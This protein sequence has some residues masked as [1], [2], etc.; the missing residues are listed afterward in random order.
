VTKSVSK[1][2]DGYRYNEAAGI[3]YNFVWHEFCDW[4]LEAIK[5]VL[6]DKDGPDQKTATLEVL[7][8]VLNDTLVLLHPFIPFIT[9]EIWHKLPGADGSIMTATYPLDDRQQT[10]LAIDSEAESEMKLVTDIITGVRNIRGEMD[11]P[12]SLQL[13]VE[14]QAEDAADRATVNTHRDLIINLAR[15]SELTTREPGRRPTAAATAIIEAGTI[16]V[17]LEGI[18]D[19]DKERERLEKRINKVNADLAPVIKKLNNEDFLNKAPQKIVANVQDKQA[20]LQQTLAKLEAT[21]A[22]VKDLSEGR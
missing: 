13:K 3:L 6:Y 17:P 15:V 11:L 8:R 12:P 14:F 5:P 16:F 4:Y 2:L 7:K 9:E 21:L 1:A 22:K 18:I 20:Q 10:A 19:L